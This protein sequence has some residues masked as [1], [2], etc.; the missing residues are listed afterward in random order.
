MHHATTRSSLA[1]GLLALMFSGAARGQAPSAA[2]PE[3]NSQQPEP[4]PGYSQPAYPPPAYPPP[5]YPT[6]TYA[7]TYVPPPAMRAPTV[8]RYEERPLYGLM[9]AGACVFGVPYLINASVAWIAGEGALAI[10]IAGPLVEI[11]HCKQCTGSDAGGRT[12]I[13]FLVFDALVQGSG[14]AMLLVGALTHQR[15]A[16]RETAKLFM[17]PAPL[18]AGAGLAAFGRF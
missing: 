7:P 17:L 10:P 3:P 16:V 1:F 12:L 15:V 8:I 2:P 5:G 14:A 6:P 9:I 18:P 4:P 13:A 11:G